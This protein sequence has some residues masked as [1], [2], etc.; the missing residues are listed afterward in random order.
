M[1]VTIAVSIR[2][3]GASLVVLGAMHRTLPE[4][5]DRSHVKTP[6]VN[7]LGGT[8]T[9]ATSTASS[10]PA[11]RVLRHNLR[12][13]REVPGDPSGALFPELGGEFLDV[14]GPDEVVAADRPP[15]AGAATPDPPSGELPGQL[16]QAVCALLG[17]LFNVHFHAPSPVRL[18]HP[19]LPL[20]EIGRGWERGNER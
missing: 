19:P 7:A 20:A 10:R 3:K 17:R 2:P 4:H 14:E 18:P 8:H 15:V 1:G 9:P 5:A 13:L 12:I 16:L 11:N 6:P